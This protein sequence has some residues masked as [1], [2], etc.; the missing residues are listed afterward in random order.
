[1]GKIIHKS[2]FN[3]LLLPAL[4]VLGPPTLPCFL[5]SDLLVFMGEIEYYGRSFFKCVARITGVSNDNTG[6]IFG[7]CHSE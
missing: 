4:I 6:S 1:M 5:P 3:E 7:T 2:S